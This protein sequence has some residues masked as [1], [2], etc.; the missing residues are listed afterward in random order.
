MSAPSTQTQ[1]TFYY[2][3][4]HTVLGPEESEGSLRRGIGHLCDAGI[5]PESEGP[6]VRM[7]YTTGLLNGHPQLH[8][9][10][11]AALKR[12]AV[13][14]NMYFPGLERDDIPAMPVA[15]MHAPPELDSEGRPMIDWNRGNAG[16][17]AA[18]TSTSTDLS[19]DGANTVA[20][21]PEQEML[22]VLNRLLAF[23][24]LVNGA[25]I[26]SALQYRANLSQ[27]Q[28]NAVNDMLLRLQEIVDAYE[29]TK[30]DAEQTL[31]ALCAEVFAIEDINEL[32]C[33]YLH[34]HLMVTFPREFIELL[35]NLC[36]Y[37]QYTP[38]VGDDAS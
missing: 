6:W 34:S 1:Q 33:A 18:S 19:G 17:A 20:V 15:L 8:E 37:G 5:P 3:F 12:F 21:E 32:F 26:K 9:Q 22:E 27:L 16:S 28:W 10:L 31:K 29:S 14:R 30:K 13:R 7:T 24:R 36:P 25:P 4:P 2:V 11:V 38:P 23:C 35:H